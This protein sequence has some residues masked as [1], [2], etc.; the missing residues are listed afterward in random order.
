MTVF[1]YQ[2]YSSRE[3]PPLDR[4]LHMLAEAGYKQVEGFR[5]VFDKPEQ[6]RVQLDAAGLSMTSAHFSIDALE[7]DRDAVFDIAATLGVESL[8]C[9]HLDAAERPTDAAGWQAF[10]GRLQKL[11]DPVRDAGFEFG[12]PN[13]AF[14]FVPLPDGTTPQQIILEDAPDIKWEADIAWIAVAGA[15]PSEWSSRYGDRITAV[16]IKDIAPAGKCADEDGWADVGHG[17]LDWAGYFRQLKSAP[18]KHWIMEHD[19]PA[20]DE[21][22]ATRSI[23]AA[24][25]F[26]AG[27]AE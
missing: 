1:S 20:D 18:V 3:F 14:E 15:D 23:N 6:T 2:L 22:F 25:Q 9:P 26:V 10:A 8:Y 27:L 5:G 16:H 12:W 11:A 19:K 4:T 17:T 24:R 7:N 13:H 21:R